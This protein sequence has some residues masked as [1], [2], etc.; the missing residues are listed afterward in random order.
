MSTGAEINRASDNENNHLLLFA[1]KDFVNFAEIPKDICCDVAG[2]VNL[3]VLFLEKN[4][5]SY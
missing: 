1:V 4:G 3:P 2:I 5:I